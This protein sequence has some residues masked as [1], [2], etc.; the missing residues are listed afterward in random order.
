VLPDAT[1]PQDFWVYNPGS[2]L[3]YSVDGDGT[4]SVVS[5][6]APKGGKLRI[7]ATAPEVLWVGNSAGLWRSSNGGIEFQQLPSVAAAYAV[8][9][10]KAAPTSSTPAIYL[11][12][13][14]VDTPE[15]VP[16]TADQTRGGGIYRSLD[17]GATWQRIDDPQHR[18]AWIEQITGDPRV[19]GRYTWGRAVGESSGETR[20]SEGRASD[21]NAT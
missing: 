6:T 10:G 11:A 12:G 14:I 20:R 15:A 5:Q 7:P 8:G 4:A 21:F 17:D 9:F 1:K 2:G 3:L 16:P 18:S 13:A 19:F